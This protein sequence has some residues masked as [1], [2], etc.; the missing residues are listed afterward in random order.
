MVERGRERGHEEMCRGSGRIWEEKKRRLC[1]LG[2]TAISWPP[3]HPR[4]DLGLGGKV[5]ATDAGEK[6]RERLGIAGGEVA[7]V[8]GGGGGVGWEGDEG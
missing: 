1:F 2:A 3:A 8:V 6:E 4:V 5:R 7:G